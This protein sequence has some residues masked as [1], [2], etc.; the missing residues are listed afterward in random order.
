MTEEFIGILEEFL[1]ISHTKIS[2]KE[3]WTRSAPEDLRATPLT[4]YLNNVS[5]FSESQ[6]LLVDSM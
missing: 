3:K 1:G 4:D 2:L 5:E 6:S